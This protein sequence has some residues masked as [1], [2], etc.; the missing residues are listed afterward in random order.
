M[1]TEQEIVRAHDTLDGI[2]SDDNT[3]ALRAR[4]KRNGVLEVVGAAR[5]VL[6]WVLNHDGGKAFGEN[7]ENLAKLADAYGLRLTRFQ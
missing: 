7:L 6:C 2:L 1:R 4:L 5:D 3:A